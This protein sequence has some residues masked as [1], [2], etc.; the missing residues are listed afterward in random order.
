MKDYFSPI[1]PPEAVNAV[2]SLGLAH[3]GD[4][5]YE[6]LVRTWLCDCGRLTSRSLHRETVAL[7]RAPAQAEAMARLLP[8][9]SEE[10]RGVYKRARNTRVNSVPKGAAIAQYH[11][12][13]GLEALFGWLHLTGR[14][15]RMNVLFS[16]AM[17]EE[18]ETDA[19]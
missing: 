10:E 9:L 7:V 18:A 13:T 1:L 11:T 8:V 5:V 4:A 12:A 14:R 19:P 6:L 2:S 17:G 3:V 16:L 15:E